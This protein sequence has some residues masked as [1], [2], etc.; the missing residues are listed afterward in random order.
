MQ[1]VRRRGCIVPFY[2][3]QPASEEI[4]TA[5]L[6]LSSSWG[7][8]PDVIKGDNKSLAAEGWHKGS[9]VKADYSST[10]GY[11]LLRLRN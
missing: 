6:T 5:V 9:S 8:D 10:K 11:S 3:L 2:W 1:Y 7:E 4:F